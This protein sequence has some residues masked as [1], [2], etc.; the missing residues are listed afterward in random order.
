M[1]EE[2]ERI[3]REAQKEVEF[4]KKFAVKELEQI[5]NNKKNELGRADVI[6]QQK[7]TS[8]EANYKWKLD[9]QK[10]DLANDQVKLQMKI[11]ELEGLKAGELRKI[12]EE[13]IK[14]KSSIE[15]R[16]K[17]IK[18]QFEITL[19]K[20]IYQIENDAKKRASKLWKI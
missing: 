14:T 19:D 17:N 10:K 5:E 8:I 2:A 20:Q 15:N 1:K 3:L 16:Y 9:F 4:K 6:Y 7:K 12:D 18:Q 11:K 13:L